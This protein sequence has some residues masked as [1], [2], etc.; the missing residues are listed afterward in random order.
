M[1]ERPKTLGRLV[2][3]SDSDNGLWYNALDPPFLLDPPFVLRP[4][5]ALK[6]LPCTRAMMC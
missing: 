2:V 1:K 6:A 3:I 4:L 5:K